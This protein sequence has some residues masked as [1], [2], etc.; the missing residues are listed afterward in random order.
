[1]FR[2]RYE[3]LQDRLVSAL[4]GFDVHGMYN[5]GCVQICLH[6]APFNG[7][8]NG[9][10][11]YKIKITK[12]LYVHNGSK[13]IHQCFRQLHVSESNIKLIWELQREH[14]DFNPYC[15]ILFQNCSIMYLSVKIFSDFFSYR[16]C[17]I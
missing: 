17:Q 11:G 1:M 15:A 6:R 12:L 13:K 9:H 10:H 3:N 2:T 14:W 5:V 8:S 4:S 16:I 7:G